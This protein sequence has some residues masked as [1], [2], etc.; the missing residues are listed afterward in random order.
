MRKVLLTVMMV[1]SLLAFNACKKDGAQG[2]AGPAG[3]TGATGAAGAV[4]PAGAAGANGTKILPTT[5][6]PAATLGA[7]GDYAFDSATKMFYGPKGATT[8]PAGIA[9]SG[10]NGATGATGATGAVGATGANGVDGSKF[11]SGPNAPTAAD[12]NIGDFYFATSTSTFYGPKTAAGWGTNTIPLGTAYAAKTY[13]ITRGFEGVTE[14]AGSKAYGDVVTE[15][16]G[17]VN[18]FSSYTVTANDMIRI[19]QYGAAGWAKNREMIFETNPGSGIWNA[20]PTNGNLVAPNA[21]TLGGPGTPFQVG[22]K[23]RY[24]ENRTLVGGYP[25]AEFT[26]TQDDIDRLT[27]NAGAAFGYL[28]YAQADL[29][30]VAL[31]STLNFS[32]TKNVNVVPATSGSNYHV[33]YTA[34]TKFNLNTL[35]PNYE[36]YKQDGKVFVKYKYYG[37][38]TSGN[39]AIIHNSGSAGWIDLTTYA[40]SYVLGTGGYGTAG[41]TDANPFTLAGAA[42]N[43]FMGSGAALGVAGSV[44]TVGVDQ[45]GTVINT[46][47]RPQVFD[48][49]NVVINWDI[50]SGSNMASAPTATPFGP[51]TLTNPTNSVENLVTGAGRYTVVLDGVRVARAFETTYYS[52]PQLTSNKTITAGNIDVINITGGKDASY[53]TNTK[54]VQVQVFVIPGDVITAL[55]AKGVDTNNPNAI[56]AN[57]KL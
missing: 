28:T 38:N 44:V 9:L 13:T 20:V 18:I 54:L 51:M 11:I 17:A 35:V 22:R 34:Q 10:A 27:V 43:N 26:L 1:S 37:D 4:G 36:K 45:V 57:I 30:T 29:A 41:V 50:N 42:T 23:F 19:N 53:F 47:A 8:W 46:I 32:S 48:K 2:P 56:S 24:S 40:N 55:K 5:G 52:A 15:T 21:G 3:A 6:A 39:N 49:G 7:T 33:K 25:V 14:V 16:P 31:G 12:G